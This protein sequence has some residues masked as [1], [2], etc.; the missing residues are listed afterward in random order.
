ML[1][2]RQADAGTPVRVLVAVDDR[3][4]TEGVLD[5]ALDVAAAHDGH[6]IGFYALEGTPREPWSKGTGARVEPEVRR[7]TEA[8]LEDTLVGAG[9]P[10]GRVET[11]VGSRVRPVRRSAPPRRP[12]STWS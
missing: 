8:W 12:T 2:V 3:E 1:V 6:V 9:F 7:A 11:A 5:A 10:E 4:A